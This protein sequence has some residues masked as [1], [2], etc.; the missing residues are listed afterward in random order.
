M[1]MYDA[2]KDGVKVVRN[3]GNID[4]SLKLAE[5]ADDLIAKNR[6][7]ADLE[8]E[9]KKLKRLKKYDFAENHEYYIDPEHPDRPLCPICTVKLETPAPLMNGENCSRCKVSYE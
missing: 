9:I 3:A 6:K 5:V 4:L 7:I 8:D 1:G 2:I